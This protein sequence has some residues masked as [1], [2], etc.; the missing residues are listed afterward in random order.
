[1]RKGRSSFREA[2]LALILDLFLERYG[3]FIGGFLYNNDIRRKS[4]L[5]HVSSLSSLVADLHFL[6]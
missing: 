3:N 2:T 4:Y 5:R 6:D 1:M